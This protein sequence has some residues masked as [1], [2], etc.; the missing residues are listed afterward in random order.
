MEDKV[1]PSPNYNPYSSSDPS[2]NVPVTTGAAGAIMSPYLNFD[3]SYLGPGGADSQFIFPEGAART[4][5]R[6]ELS[7]SQIGASVF[8]GAA[9]GGLNGLYS[10]VKDVQ[11]RQLVG[12]N[13]RTQLLNFI[14]KGG[15]STAQTLG[16]VALMYSVFGV[17]L[18]QGRGVDDELNTVVAGTA[19]GMLYK[20]SAGW[21]RCLRGGGIGLGL[22]AAYVLFTSRDRI[23]SVLGR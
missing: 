10:G 15:A 17:I 9:V 8:V 18:S 23:K 19:T 11:A 6:L 5:G 12:A 3:P 4:R 13:R 22:S 2:M 21:K 20:S 1:P 14:T 7:F 16:V